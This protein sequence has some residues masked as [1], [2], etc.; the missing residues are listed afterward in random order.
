[1][2]Q[3]LSWI[4]R[5]AAVIISLASITAWMAGG[6]H[7]GW[8]QTQVEET[9]QDEFT[10]IE[11]PVYREAF[12]PGLELLAAGLLLSGSLGAVSLI[13]QRSRKSPGLQSAG[14]ARA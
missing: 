10:G 4:L 1:M 14:H 12:V 8:T 7:R 3:R 11:Y 2:T 5:L 9:H 13:K 6:S